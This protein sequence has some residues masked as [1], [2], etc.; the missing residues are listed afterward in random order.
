MKPFLIFTPVEPDSQRVLQNKSM[1]YWTT[2]MSP[3]QFCWIRVEWESQTRRARVASES[4]KF[5]SSAVKVESWLIE[6]GSSHFESLVC[7][8]ES[9][10]IQQ[11]PYDFLNYYKWCLTSYKIAP[12]D[13]NHGTQ[14]PT[15]RRPT[16]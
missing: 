9:H 13:L 2:V 14:W 11:F 6:S 5:F 12:N 15:K 16:S 4:S 1:A 8:L 7:E 3:R 10:E